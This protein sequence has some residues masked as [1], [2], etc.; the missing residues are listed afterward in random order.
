MICTGLCHFQTNVEQHCI[1]YSVIVVTSNSEVDDIIVCCRDYMDRFLDEQENPATLDRVSLPAVSAGLHADDT[2][3]CSQVQTDGEPAVLHEGDGDTSLRAFNR[4]NLTVATTSDKVEMLSTSELS[5]GEAAD[6][7]LANSVAVK[8]C[9]DKDVDSA[10]AAAE[11]TLRAPDSHISIGSNSSETS[12]SASVLPSLCH[13]KALGNSQI[14]DMVTE[15]ADSD[16]AA[17][18]TVLKKEK[19]SSDVDGAVPEPSEGTAVSNSGTVVAVCDH[20][21]DG[22]DREVSISECPHGPD[23]HPQSTSVSLDAELSVS[24][25]RRESAA[26]DVDVVRPADVELLLA[27]VDSATSV[28]GSLYSSVDPLTAALEFS[29]SA[30]VSVELLSNRTTTDFACQQDRNVTNF[31]MLSSSQKT[32]SQ[33]SEPALSSSSPLLPVSCTTTPCLPPDCTDVLEQDDGLVACK[34]DSALVSTTPEVTH[35][36]ECDVEMLVDERP[37]TIESINGNRP[38]IVHDHVAVSNTDKENNTIELDRVQCPTENELAALNS[39]QLTESHLKSNNIAASLSGPDAENTQA[40]D[41]DII[42]LKTNSDS[43]SFSLTS[44]DIA[45]SDKTGEQEQSLDVAEQSESTD[46]R[47]LLTVTSDSECASTAS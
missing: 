37:T 12:K 46:S 28:A 2:K 18:V 13:D 15:K 33:P 3:P 47:P 9:A 42:S 24:T 35:D 41:T 19:P 43:V 7:S 16:C 4:E 21:A 45:L 20:Q 44:G 36:A 39:S 25:V 22:D 29:S 11:A 27:A 6:S 14:E 1:W 32:N 8:I 30:N 34:S 10:V 38:H 17:A 5:V 26:A 23:N 40:D 31:S